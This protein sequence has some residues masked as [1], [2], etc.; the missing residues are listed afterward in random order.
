ME[1]GGDQI[2]TSTKVCTYLTY[3]V[4]VCT[5][6]WDGWINLYTFLQDILLGLINLYT[7]YASESISNL[8]IYDST[9]LH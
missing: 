4:L 9:Y 1:R 6:G 7:L 8:A 2:A 5:M 3:T